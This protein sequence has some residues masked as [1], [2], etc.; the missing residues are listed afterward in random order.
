M[1]I[2]QGD[3]FSFVEV[4]GPEQVL[5]PT[6]WRRRPTLI[7]LPSGPGFSHRTLSPWLEGLTD[8]LRVVAVDLPG[9]G[10]GSLAAGLDYGFDSYAGDLEA[11]RQALDVKNL[12]LLGHGWGAAMAIEYAI[13]H[14]DRVSSLMLI[15]PIRVF[16]GEGQDVEAQA[17]MVEQ[18]DPDLFARWAEAAGPAFTQALGGKGSWDAVEALPWWSQMVRTQFS[19][20][21]PEAWDRATGGAPW[22]MRAYATYKG[23]AM[24]DPASAM[25]AYD[26]SER[27]RGVAQPTLILACDHDANYVAPPARHAVPLAEAMT[28]ARLVIWSDAGHFPF[29]ERPAEFVALVRSLCKENFAG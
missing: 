4:S 8:D 20:P 15:N 29:V 25:A 3:R 22:R 14:P 11:V 6:G 28:G 12:M 2:G 19:A 23:A 9:S 17:R 1:R 10:A 18:V 26:L 13:A 16:T 5:E 7:A 21:P 24:F 27:A